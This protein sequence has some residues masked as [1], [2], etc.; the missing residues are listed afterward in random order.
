[1]TVDLNVFNKVLDIGLWVE[2][3]VFG[4]SGTVN[5]ELL[6]SLFGFLG[7]LNIIDRLV[8]GKGKLVICLER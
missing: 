2:N 6:G 4:W 3:T 8:Q 5:D 1:M 7:L